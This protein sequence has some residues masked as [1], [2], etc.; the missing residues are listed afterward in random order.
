MV[1]QKINLAPTFRDNRRLGDCARK[2]LPIVS[3]FSRGGPGEIVMRKAGIFAAAVLIAVLA[4]IGSARAEFGAIAYDQ[5]TGHYG[6]SWNET[7]P[8]RAAELAKKDCGTG[9]C[10]V[11]PVSPRQCGALATAENQKESTAWG[12]SI[13]PNKGDAEARAIADCQKHT[14]GQC[15]VKGSECNR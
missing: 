15:K 13:R 5:G 7:A 9:D 4:G 2:V 6:F 10:R 12:V 3:A 14:Q 8:Q 1:A 11:F